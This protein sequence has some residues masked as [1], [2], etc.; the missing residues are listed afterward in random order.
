MVWVLGCGGGGGEDGGLKWF[1]YW[2]ECEVVVWVDGWY[3]RW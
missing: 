3:G 2:L 1:S